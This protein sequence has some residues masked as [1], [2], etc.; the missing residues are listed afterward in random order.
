MIL[1]TDNFFFD[2]IEKYI[3]T[4]WDTQMCLNIIMSEKRLHPTD[5]PLFS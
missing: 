2:I 5:P 3:D 4:F 1:A